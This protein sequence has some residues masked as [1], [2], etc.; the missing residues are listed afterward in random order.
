MQK[1]ATSSEV[2]TGITL[3]IDTGIYYNYENNTVGNMPIAYLT[4]D[5]YA[6]CADPSIKNISP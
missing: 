1:T 2:S 5:E 4:L 3:S 6:P